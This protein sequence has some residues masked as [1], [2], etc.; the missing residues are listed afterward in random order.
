MTLSPSPLGPNLWVGD[1]VRIGEDVELGV[2]VV[3]HDG[4]V[5]ED[6][7]AVDHGAVI[8]KPPR[9]GPH[10]RTAALA[11]AGPEPTVVGAG[12]AVGCGAVVCAG[13]RLEARAV[14]GNQALIRERAV[15]GPESV[16]G[17]GCSIGIDVRIGAR[18]RMMGGALVG[19]ATTIEDDVFVGPSF[20][21]LEDRSAGRWAPGDEPFPHAA[22][23]RGC[24][25]GGSVILL[26]GTEIGE[27]AFV[28][29]GSLVTRDV[30]A[31]MLAIGAPARVRGPAPA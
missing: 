22:L 6:G 31:G 21:V 17:L 14:V 15:V 2:N 23:R 13:A 7:C 3:L 28:A 16:V 8:G 24:R 29:A 26:A 20:S 5:L 30:P 1:D 4:A 11:P 27:A 12:A 25:I 9:L 10:S 19:W 18:V